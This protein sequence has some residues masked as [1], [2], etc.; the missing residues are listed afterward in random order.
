[1]KNYV[2]GIS[3]LYHNS[4]AV[5]LRNGEIAFA[6][7]EERFT[8]VKG[9]ASFPIN[10]IRFC[11]DAEGIF[12]RDLTAVAYYENPGVKFDRIVIGAF[13]NMPKSVSQF[14]RAV[15]DWITNKLWIE[16]KIRKELDYSG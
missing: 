11:L 7:E 4:A 3:C 5:L 8:R 6:A 9:D 16:R 2:L 12:P 15:P 14:V 1:M 13:L 10:A